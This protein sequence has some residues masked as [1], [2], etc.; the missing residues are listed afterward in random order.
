MLLYS[1]YIFNKTASNFLAFMA[2]LIALIWFSRS[3]GFVS[4]VTENGVALKQFFYLFLLI[5]PW[6]LLFIIPVSL[7]AAI[8]LIYNRLISSNEISILKNSGLTKFSISKPIASLA[9]ITSLLCFLISFYAMPYANRELRLSRINFQNN[10]ANLSF[11]PQTFETL[12][13]LTIYAKN[14]DETNHLFGILLHDERSDKYSITITAK[15][16]N[17]VTESNSALLYMVDGTVQKFNYDNQKTEILNFDD[18]VFN[19]TESKKAASG[20]HWKVKE[21]YLNELLNPE[22]DL[23]ENELKKF[24]AELSQRFT[25]PLLPIMF[26]LI[27]AAFVLRGNFNRHGNVLNIVFAIITAVLF[28]LSLMFIYSL[29]ESSEKFTSLLYLDFA[30]FFAASLAL[31]H[32]KSIRNK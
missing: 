14:R 4:Y 2:V 21:R 8:L 9:I 31:L 19:L 13:N 18:Y 15:S 10:Y 28:L 1:K 3:I 16:G 29:I 12:R 26:S 22:A 7:F 17:I 24:R 30:I 6:L 23:D 32:E 27:A 11:S 25:Y 5:L 20:F